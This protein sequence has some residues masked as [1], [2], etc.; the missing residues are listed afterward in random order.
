MAYSR[1]T[2]ANIIVGA[3]ALFTYEDGP[4]GQNTSGGITNTQAEIDLPDFQTNISYKETLSNDVD[5]R[6]VGY[7]M[8][9][10][11]IVFQ[12]DFGEVQVDQVLDVAKLYKQGMQVNLNTAFAEATLDNLLFAVAGQSSDLSSIYTSATSQSAFGTPTYDG[13]R[14]LNLGAG[15]IGE[16]PVER[17]LVA[18]GPGTGDCAAGSTIERVYVG[19]R[20]LSIES[21]T[22]SAKRDEPTMFEVSFRLLPNDNASYGKIV[23]RT[24]AS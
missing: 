11:E 2:S 3:A 16:C 12:P 23:D 22:V 4:I 20:A 5:Y 13:D 24:L 6:N 18:V 10:L 7:T 19:Y 21:V 9:G 1:G 14:V 8:N 15:N 17:G